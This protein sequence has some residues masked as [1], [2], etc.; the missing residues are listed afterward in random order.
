CP[1]AATAPLLTGA[2]IGRCP[3]YGVGLVPDRLRAE[4]GRPSTVLGGRARRAH[5][6]DPAR[7]GPAGGEALLP[8]SASGPLGGHPCA[9]R[10]GSPPVGTAFHVPRVP[11]RGDR[12]ME[13]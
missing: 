1:R 8:H 9:R 11:L 5:A 7:G 13:R 3:P 4:P 2:A 10:Q 6:P 12:G